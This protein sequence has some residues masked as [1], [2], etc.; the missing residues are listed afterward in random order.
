MNEKVLIPSVESLKHETD[1]IEY[2][3]LKMSSSATDLWTIGR[4]DHEWPVVRKKMLADVWTAD[5][6]K[7]PSDSSINRCA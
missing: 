4:D 7:N 3:H 2:L 1:T 6:H 5:P